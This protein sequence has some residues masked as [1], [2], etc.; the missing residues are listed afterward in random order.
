MK[1]RPKLLGCL[2]F[3][4]A[5]A[6]STSAVAGDD[7]WYV[8]GV[9]VPDESWRGH[10]GAFLAQLILTDNANAI[11]EYWNNQPGAMKV[12]PISKVRPGVKASAIAFFA[13]CQ[14]DSNGNCNVWGKVSIKTST[15]RVL[16]KDIDVPLWVGRPPPGGD[17]LGI[18]EQDIGLIVEDFDGSYTFQ[19]V[20]SDRIADRHISLTQILTVLK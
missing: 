4:V 1:L 20:V 16:G 17:A 19:V 7:G 13:H 11:Y 12:A 18:A 3:M 6:I 10:D 5:I 8:D 2:L 15:G 9:L 14:P